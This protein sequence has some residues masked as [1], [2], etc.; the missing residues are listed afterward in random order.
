MIDYEHGII[1]LGEKESKILT[2]T[3]MFQTPMGLYE[4]PADAVEDLRKNGLP[5]LALKPVAVA[6]GA[7]HGLYEVCP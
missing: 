5:V 1:R 4:Q 2:Y 3:V 6:I 7:D